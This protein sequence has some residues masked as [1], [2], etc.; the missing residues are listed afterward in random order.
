MNERF[1]CVKLDRE[2]RPDLDAIYME[3]CQA[4][5]GR[6][7]WPLNV[8]LTPEQVP[9]YA[10]TYFPPEERHG[11]PSW[12]NVLH[13]RGR[14]LGGEERTRSARAASAWPSGWPAP[15][16]CSRRRSRWT[17]ALARR[18][19]R[20]AA[21][22]LRRAQRRLRRRAEV[23][24][25]LGD[26]VPAAPR[27]DRDDLA[28]PPRDGARRHVRPG[29]RRL[30]PLLGGRPLAGPP[31]REDA[32][33]QRAAGPRVPAR[34]AGDR[35]A[36]VPAGDRGDARLDAARRCARPR[37]AS[38]PRSTPTPR[39]RRACSTSGR[40]EQLREVLG[41]GRRRGGR[42]VLRREARRQLRGRAP[43]SPA[44]PT[45]RRTSTRSA[46]S[47]TRPEPSASGPASTTSA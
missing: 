21:R 26:R 28:H 9:F 12:R 5:T 43:S 32:L 25:R 20:A 18:R 14:R 24:A 22:D 23:P 27:R 15:R 37:A 17:R 39:A 42:G 33:R 10:G 2:E 13:G 19:G 31:L 38:T 35:R 46:P 45:S 29:G 6:G 30:R 7:G 16:R 8:F 4:M 34:L 36:P 3:A 40:P 11:M 47:S 41:P 1:V 44:E